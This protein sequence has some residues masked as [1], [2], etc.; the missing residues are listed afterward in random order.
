MM[1]THAIS[2]QKHDDGVTIRKAAIGQEAEME[3]FTVRTD[4]TARL[5]KGCSCEVVHKASVLYLYSSI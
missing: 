4:A 3:V 2:L 5:S 1:T